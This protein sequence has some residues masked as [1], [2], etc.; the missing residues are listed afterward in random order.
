MK[1]IKTKSGDILVIE[2][3]ENVQCFIT[4]F[5]IHLSKNNFK[6][7]ETITGF[8]SEQVLG[9]FSELTDKDGE[10]F[11]ESIK[12]KGQ[13]TKYNYFYKDYLTNTFTHGSSKNSFIS[14]LQ[15][16]GIDTSKEDE[17][18]IIKVL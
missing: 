12:K 7:G 5:G 4:E 18:L 6:T 11:V 8:G 14:L 16:E 2:I 1:Q 17:L 3:L 15:S 13:F 9:K 10:D